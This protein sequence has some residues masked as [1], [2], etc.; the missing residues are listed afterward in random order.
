MTQLHQESISLLCTEVLDI[1]ELN[2]TPESTRLH[3]AYSEPIMAEERFRDNYPELPPTVKAF[4]DLSQ[5][6]DHRILQNLLRNEDKYLPCVPDYLN[7]VQEM[8]VT[9]SMRKIVAQWMLEVIHEQQSQPEVFCLA[10]NILDRFLSQCKVMKA[11]LQLLGS[12]CILIS[13][14]IREPCPI[15]G[16]TLIAYTDYS[17]TPDELKEWELLILHTLQWELTAITSMDY[18]DHTIP[19]LCLDISTEEQEDIRRRAETILALCA[20][21]YTFSYHSASLLAASSLMIA[22]KSLSK[23]QNQTLVLREI[24][25]RLQ[26]ATHTATNHLHRA[27]K[28]LILILP[29]YLKPPEESHPSPDSTSFKPALRRSHSYPVTLADPMT[30]DSTTPGGTILTPEPDLFCKEYLSN[31]SALGDEFES[32]DGVCLPTGSPSS[33]SSSPLSAVDIFTDYN[34]HV[35]Q[36]VFEQAENMD[37]H[38]SILVS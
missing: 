35:L 9:P 15:P 26:T 16:Q 23:F 36:A 8:G 20:T 21:D 24:Q 10:M 18:L 4:E 6:K 7:S 13:S 27:V 32:T 12:V 3:S 25:L 29:D 28:D 14:K 33:R 22:V 30:V 38:C 19:R 2:K 17:I 34:T 37:S 5:V 1:G 31:D 11:Q